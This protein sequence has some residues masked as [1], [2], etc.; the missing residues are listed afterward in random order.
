MP[1]AS[2]FVSVEKRSECDACL[3]HRGTRM[4]QLCHSKENPKL[5]I[6]HIYGNRLLWINVVLNKF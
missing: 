5:H 3:P 4:A 1:T 6:P 2:I